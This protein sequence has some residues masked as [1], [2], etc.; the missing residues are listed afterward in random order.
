M[1]LVTPGLT[2]P[3]KALPSVSTQERVAQLAGEA[4][5]DEGGMSV[6]PVYERMLATGH[7]HGLIS[8][9]TAAFP[10]HYSLALRPQH[11][12]LMVCQGV[13][14]HVDLNAEAVRASWVSHEGKKELVVE[15][16]DFVMGQSNAWDSVVSGKPDSFAAQI[17]KN[18]VAGVPELLSPPFSSTSPTEDV[19]QKIVVMDICKHYFSYKCLTL[20]GF[21]KIILE[22]TEADWQL[23]R[24][25]AERLLQRCEPKFA[26]TWGTA[27]LP[28][29]EKLAAARRGEVDSQFWNS[30]CKRGGTQGSGSYTWFNGWF[31]ILFPFI[32]KRPNAYC[33]PYSSGAGYVKEGLVWDKT[34]NEDDFQHPTPKGVA[35]PDCEDFGSG[36]SSAPVAWLYCGKEHQ[37]NFNAGFIG[38]V[39]DATTLCIRPQIGWYITFKLDFPRSCSE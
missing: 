33:V 23:L 28:L 31:N 13:A 3:T 16:G 35:G 9:V 26:A 12:W 11:F 21:P 10:E 7:R 20:C 34:Y 18:T 19:A 8:A 2:L 36:I 14:T 24:D 6:A 17:E 1:L 15:C 37:L 5:V 22:G 25:A 38:A 30:M 27:L 39:Q 4:L 32:E 29:L